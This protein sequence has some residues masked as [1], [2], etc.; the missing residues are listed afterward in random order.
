MTADARVR[1]L[2]LLNLFAVFSA[3]DPER[4]LEA[5]VANYTKDVIWSDPEATPRATRH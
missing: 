4:R 3:R 5:I 2:L 1:E